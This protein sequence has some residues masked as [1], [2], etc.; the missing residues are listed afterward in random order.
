MWN[1]RYW[2]A[3]QTGEADRAALQT[4]RE[5]LK[6][7]VAVRENIDADEYKRRVRWAFDSESAYARKAMLTSAQSVQSL[8]TKASDYDRDPFLLTV[9]NGTLDLHTG[10]LRASSPDDLITQNTD[11]PYVPE[12][13]CPRWH[14]FLEEVFAGKRTLISFVQRAVGYT[15]CGDTREQCLFILYGGGAN[16][17]STFLEVILRLLGTYAAITSFSTFLVHQNPGTPRNDVAKL[18]G[19]RLVKAAESQKQAALDEATVKEVTGGDTISARFLFKEFFDFRPQFKIWLATNH[20]PSIQGTDD[21]IWRRI[22]LIPFD[23]Q[24]TGKQRDSKLRDKLEAELSGILAWAVRGCLE[25]Q[26]QGLGSAPVVDKATLEYRRESDAVGRFL[27]DRCTNQSTDQVGGRELFA[28]YAEWCGS[29][30]EKAESNN[31][32]AKA[33]DQRGIGKKRTSKGTVYLGVGLRHSLNPRK[34]P[35][36]GTLEFSIPVCR[37][38]GSCSPLTRLSTEQFFRGSSWKRLHRA[39]WLHNG[40]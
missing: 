5:R 11:V 32:F 40:K 7:I 37:R 15:L 13:P 10:K 35:I 38:D 18:H 20:R 22:K 8:A 21:A 1:G 33:L 36:R 27:S 30:G 31:T 3:D 19:A 6:A 17:K 34:Q 12:V 24:F 26:R 25:W 39:T 23:Q 9:G 2:A 16:G 28:A 4:A 14:Q 29:K